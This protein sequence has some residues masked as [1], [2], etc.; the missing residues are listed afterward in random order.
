MLG[1]IGTGIASTVLGTLTG[2]PDLAISGVNLAGRT[3]G[4]GDIITGPTLQQRGMEAAGLASEPTSQEAAIAYYAP[5]VITGVYGAASLLKGGMKGLREAYTSR[6]IKRFTDT[7]PEAEA[8]TFKDFMLKGQG[9]D[10]PRL[11]AVLQKLSSNPEYAEIFTKLQAGATKAAT[12]GIAPRASKLTPEAATEGLVTGVEDK[13]KAL[14]TARAEAGNVAFTK[15]AELGGDRS[16]V[17]VDNTLTKVRALKARF[18][19]GLTE[20]SKKAVD[21]LQSIEDTLVPS[22]Q[23]AA[24][25]GT[26]V[27]IPA[28]AGNS[29]MG[30]PAKAG[31]AFT[32]PGATGYTTTL[33]QKQLTVQQAQS[34]LHEFGVRAA[35]GESLV[36][37]LA[38]SDQKVISSAIFGGLKDDLKA[39][40]GLAD[41]V[42]DKQAIGHLISAREQTKNASEAY[43][44]A[45]SQGMPSFLQNKSLA[46][47]SPEELT[48][49]YAGLTP[50]QQNVFRSY[51]G[52]TRKEAL[53][54]LDKG[55]YDSFV[56]SATKELP[57]GTM[58]I[59]LGTL[60]KRWF[61]MEPSEKNALAASLG[62]NLNEF[63]SRMKDA[64]VFSRKM[65]VSGVPG[66][67]K[68]VLDTAGKDIAAA[69][70]AT[71][72]YAAAK[73]TT[74]T[75]DALKA[76]KSTGLSEEQL[77]K[78]L[79]TK[80]GSDFLKAGS[81]SPASAK[82]LD[83][84]TKVEAVSPATFK[85]PLFQ[86]TLAGGVS[87][88]VAG[89]PEQQVETPS[90]TM[91]DIHPDILNTISTPGVQGAPD[92]MPDINPNVFGDAAPSVSSS[93]ASTP[94]EK[95]SANILQR[96]LIKAQ[97]ALS[98]AQT[99]EEQGR[100]QGDVAALQREIARLPK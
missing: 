2:L 100:A 73:A 95:D 87:K 84:L 26:A 56:K 85:N 22:F 30:L 51:V 11:A 42:S 43:T 90:M 60:A 4:K 44:Q 55:T 97:S 14:Q 32:I 27:N 99:P 49:V 59:D 37:D 9:S 58:G 69:V 39:S 6:K 52:D 67:A 34:L 35:K 50:T 25:G 92:G 57:D 10:D 17:S 61:T 89:A 8:N 63:S 33:P 16:I 91:P 74:L 80:E 46:E 71:G 88:Q 77:M 19:E 21:F 15:A 31:S 36:N 65:Q 3:F 79:M 93:F 53:Q 70:G 68:G 54:F 86:A 40:I 66:E 62:Q 41:N 23:T 5:D 82:T 38:I 20:S 47:I 45:I 28:V 94:A 72:G 81:L 7:L 78:V 29:L 98:L 48:K 13:I 12:A 76:L 24:R 64:L 83:A 96:E 75:L 1:E 18:S